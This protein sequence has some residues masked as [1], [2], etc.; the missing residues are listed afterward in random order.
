V[1]VWHACAAMSLMPSRR[2]PEANIFIVVGIRTPRA[3]PFTRIA[4]GKPNS[5]TIL[6]FCC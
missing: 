2:D 3:S 4:R 1:K 5:R 6:N